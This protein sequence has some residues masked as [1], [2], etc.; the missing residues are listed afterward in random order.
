MKRLAEV[1]PD[2]IYSVPDWRKGSY[3]DLCEIKGYGRLIAG[4]IA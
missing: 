2:V 4:D 1:G 3:V